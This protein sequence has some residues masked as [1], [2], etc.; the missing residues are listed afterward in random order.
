MLR[1][2]QDRKLLY[3]GGVSMAFDPDKEFKFS[4]ASFRKQIFD[5]PT[6][7]NGFIRSVLP[8]LKALVNAKDVQA[9]DNHVSELLNCQDLY[10]A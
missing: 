4:Q 8:H 6:F 7:R 1:F 5:D 10:S 9:H 3:G 2:M